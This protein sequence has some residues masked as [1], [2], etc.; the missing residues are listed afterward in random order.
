L[1][2]R[3]HRRKIIEGLRILQFLFGLEVGSVDFNGK[4]PL[5]VVE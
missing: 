3:A 2:S 1:P 4:L 5:A